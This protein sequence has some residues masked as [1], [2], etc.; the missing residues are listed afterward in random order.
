MQGTGRRQGT[1]TM[2]CEEQ[3]ILLEIYKLQVA[4][5]YQAVQALK[6]ANTM[7]ASEFSRRTEVAKEELESCFAVLKGLN[8][9]VQTHG[10][11]LELGELLGVEN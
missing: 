8:D 11:R 2:G 10:C 1:I 3:C 4:S 9:H 5:Y 6:E 7:S